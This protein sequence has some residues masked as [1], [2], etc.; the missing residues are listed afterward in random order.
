MHFG[1]NSPAS[2]MR[3][4]LAFIG[5]TMQLTKFRARSKWIGSML[6]I[7]IM[8]RK[9]LLLLLLFNWVLS[10]VFCQENTV[11]VGGNVSNSSGSVSYTLGQVFFINAESDDGAINQGIQQPFTSEIITGIE[12]KEIELQ[13]Y[14]NPTKETAIL[15]I[16]RE[17]IG[18][19]NYTLFDET[20]RL[21]HT[22]KLNSSENPITLSELANGIYILNVQNSFQTVK[23]FRIIKT[24]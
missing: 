3:E 18:L 16:D 10:P 7:R 23:S 2:Q 24:K 15:K 9:E 13:L 4:P 1:Q 22:D 21:I 12:L 8:K 20:G 6:Y 14:P 5:L 11:T 17:Y 19:L